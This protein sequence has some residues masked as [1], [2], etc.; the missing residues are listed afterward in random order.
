MNIAVLDSIPFNPGDLEW[1]P[2]KALGSLTVFEATPPDLVVERLQG[3]E[4]VFVNKVRLDKRHFCKAKSLKLVCLLATGYD[5]VNVKDAAEFNI[6]VC[7]APAYSTASVVQMTIGL[8]LN[9]SFRL[10]VHNDAVH[11]GAWESAEAFSFWKHALVEL[12]GKTMVI[13]GMGTIGSKVAEIAAVFGM[14]IIALKFPGR[15]AHKQYVSLIPEEALPLADVLSLHCPLT[16]E[17]DKFLDQ[18][19]LQMMKPGAWIINTARGGVVDEQDVADAL[20]SGQI[21]AYACDVL[22]TEPP[23]PQNPLLSA[24]NCIITPHIAWATKEARQRLMDI[25][26]ANLRAFQNKLPINVVS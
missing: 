18:D 9:I 13:A 1:T 14:K 2:I 23:L 6:I 20:N 21:A 15:Q 26:V 22:S 5:N 19:L 24:Q 17:T 11:Q 8:L 25:S 4:V 16:T 7:N 3:V 12:A 10:D